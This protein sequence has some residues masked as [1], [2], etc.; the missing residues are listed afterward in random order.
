MTD[1]TLLVDTSR[2]Y[3]LGERS[4]MFAILIGAMLAVALALGTYLRL[5]DSF[6]IGFAVTVVV[7][8]LLL[9]GMAASLLQRDGGMLT[10]LTQEAE[11]GAAQVVRERE[12]AR[13]SVVINN[14]PTYHRVAMVLGVLALLLAVFFG[15]G[16]RGVA[17]GLLLLVAAQLV[18][19]HY[20]ES[21]ARLYES[22]LQTL[23]GSAHP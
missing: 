16:A 11:S 14:Y 18:I 3:F 5:R 23:Q 20:S 15:A 7:A 21:R 12:L 10:A 9:A 22:R 8:A 2:D 17:T 6:A 13:I 1:A 19:D 4:E